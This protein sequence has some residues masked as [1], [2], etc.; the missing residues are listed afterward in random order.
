MRTSRM[1]DRRWLWRTL[2]LLAFSAGLCLGILDTW[3]APLMD[4]PY[5]RAM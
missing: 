2:A 3:P 4:E 1:P 5:P